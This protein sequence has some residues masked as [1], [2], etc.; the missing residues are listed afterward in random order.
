MPPLILTIQKS[1]YYLLLHSVLYVFAIS[2]EICSY[3]VTAFIGNEAQTLEN[4]EI[5]TK[6]YI[7]SLSKCIMCSRLDS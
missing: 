6:I 4:V 5:S 3:L 7:F 1:K 2:A